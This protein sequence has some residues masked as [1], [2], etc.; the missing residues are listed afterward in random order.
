[1]YGVKTGLHMDHLQ[2]LSDLVTEVSG[3]PPRPAKPITGRHMFLRDNPDAQ[4]AYL[5]RGPDVFPM[6]NACV[7]PVVVG[8]RFEIVWG[9][10]Q[11]R[12]VLRA[13]VG[14]LG[15]AASEEQIV[16]IQDAIES[17]R[18]SL[19]TYPQWVTE[20]EVDGICRQILAR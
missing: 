3:L 2:R 9:T 10:R 14:H 5:T 16:K 8:G 13:K 12:E 1:M 11:S 6:P 20:A 4:L 18:A 15:L 17:R 7:A 19:A